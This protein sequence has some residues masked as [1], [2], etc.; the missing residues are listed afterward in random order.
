MKI[1]AHII[2][3]VC[4]LGLSP[5]AFAQ[6]TA[7]PAEGE[8][9]AA[10]SKTPA[11]G[12]PDEVIRDVFDDWQVR[13]SEIRQECYMYQ[14]AIDAR[15]VP[16]AEVSIVALKDR[17][18]VKAGITVVTPLRTS[19]AEGLLLQIDNGQVQ[20]YQYS[21]CT[22]VGCF[23]RFGVTENGVTAFKRGN[24]ARLTVTSIERPNSPVILDVS[25][26]GFTA[27]YNSLSK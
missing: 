18:N 19:L 5:I 3:T 7:A 12:V 2:A 10:E 15:E 4:V 6:D 13:C 16:V 11:G 17:E 24:K 23:S 20:K 26:K 9:P 22:E 1:V 14:L 25:L 21:W 27:A 8:A